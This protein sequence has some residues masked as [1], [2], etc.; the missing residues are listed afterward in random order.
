[1]KNKQ[2][3]GYRALL[4]ALLTFATGALA[5][6]KS[7]TAPAPGAKDEPVFELSPFEV[8]SEGTGYTGA[9]TLAGNHLNT[10][11][12]DIGNAVTVITAQFLKDIGA[13][14]NQTL[15]QYTTNTEVG[16]VFGNFVGAGDGSLVD[17]SAH[18]TSPN[19]N[20][21][22]RG[23]TAA[24]NTRDYFLTN[25][26]WDGYNVDGVDL[27]RGPNS[28][29]FGQGSSRPVSSIPARSRLRSRTRTRS[30]SASAAG[31][32]PA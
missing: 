15:L 25:I 16:S 21:R 30:P 26:P 19:Q 20:T 12:R 14:D 31:A 29:L 22:I 24:D 6:E 10:E 11:V 9:T 27:Q 13:T 23:L 18:F 28:I 32:A 7:T 4:G 1:M 3:L 5:Q 8:T 2:L 17:E